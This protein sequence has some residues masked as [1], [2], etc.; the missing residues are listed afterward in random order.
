MKISV[1]IVRRGHTRTV[2]ATTVENVCA[3][4]VMMAEQ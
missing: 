3:K 4:C 2:Y 1:D